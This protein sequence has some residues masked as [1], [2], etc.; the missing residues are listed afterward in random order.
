ML[1]PIVGMNYY[2]RPPKCDH[3]GRGD[4]PFHIGKS[5]GGWCF[6]LHATTE[7]RSLGEHLDAWTKPGWTIRNEEG[8][9]LL[10]GG[11]I[12]IITNRSW[13]QGRTMS[14]ED[15]RR[16]HTV[17]GPE[18]LVRFAVDGTHCVGHGPGT[19]DLIKGEFS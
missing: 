17:P 15:L 3:C 12:N 13:T 1:E 2:L 4:E 7:T 6:S 10:P 14:E 16:N 19:W 9:I 18:G 5:S 11:M 8:V